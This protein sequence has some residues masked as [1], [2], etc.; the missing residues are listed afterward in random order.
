MITTVHEHTFLILHDIGTLLQVS[1]CQ[2]FLSLTKPQCRAEMLNPGEPRDSSHGFI[3]A[4]TL[5]TISFS[6]YPNISWD[7]CKGSEITMYAKQFF[8]ASVLISFFLCIALT[9][10]L[11]F[12][13]SIRKYS[14]G[15][16]KVEVLKTYER[17][18]KVL[19]R[20]ESHYW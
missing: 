10:L 1:L 17:V 18:M 16:L 2:E 19:K 15:L 5:M 4:N 14:T 11:V 9:Y 13:M 3:L 12:K 7:L 20:K 6:I 8:V